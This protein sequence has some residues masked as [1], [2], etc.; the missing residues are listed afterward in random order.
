[1]NPNDYTLITMTAKKWHWRARSSSLYISQQIP[2]L[3]DFKILF[4]SSV[5]SLA[6]LIGMYPSLSSLKKVVYFHENQ[7]VYPK[8]TIKDRDF[9]Y[10]FNQITTWYILLL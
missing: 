4:C 9:Q 2:D 7:I 5:L 8:Q 3:K 10:G 1:M 6:E